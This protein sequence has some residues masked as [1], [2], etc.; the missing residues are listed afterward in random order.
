[1]HPLIVISMGGISQTTNAI[2][3]SFSSLDSGDN[4]FKGLTFKTP[5]PIV[6]I[7]EDLVAIVNSE[8]KIQVKN[9]LY[10]VDSFYIAWSSDN[11]EKWYF[12]DGSG[13]KGPKSLEFL[14]PNYNNELTIPAAKKSYKIKP[15]PVQKLQLKYKTH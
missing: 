13:F 6:K 9:D 4:A 14:F 2:K 12:T 5:D 1:M 7:R 11:G 8:S 10:Q 3:D 15:A